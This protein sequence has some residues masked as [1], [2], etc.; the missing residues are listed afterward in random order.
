MGNF[1]KERTVFISIDIARA[2]MLSCFSRVQLFETL[3][4]VALQVP[5]PRDSPD[6][7]TRVGCYALPQGIFLTQGW[8]LG[9][10]CLLH[11]G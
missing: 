6:R 7:N 4:I 2:C 5:L 10:L 11:C 1:W 3:W 9:L 8:N